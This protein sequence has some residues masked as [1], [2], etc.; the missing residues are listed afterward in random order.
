ML[1][2]SLSPTPNPPSSPSGPLGVRDQGHTWPGPAQAQI[3][4]ASHP[5]TILLPLPHIFSLPHTHLGPGLGE[6]QGHREKAPIR[7]AQ[8]IFQGAF[9]Q[10][11]AWASHPGRSPGFCIR[12]GGRIGL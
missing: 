1:A 7:K 9:R 11:R 3:S 2:N 5:Q 12:G 4:L 10:M 8:D 6:V